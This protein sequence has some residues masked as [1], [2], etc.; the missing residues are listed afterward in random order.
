M[1]GGN[2]MINKTMEE[3]RAEFE[4]AQKAYTAAQN[5]L[6]QKEAE[7][8]AKREKELMTKKE[9]RYKELIGVGETYRNLLKAYMDDYGAVYTE[10]DMDAVSAIPL[11]LWP[12]IL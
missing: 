7:E 6:A 12:F 9:A 4:Q 10:S 11:L 5:L 1:I 3:L 8:A 2:H